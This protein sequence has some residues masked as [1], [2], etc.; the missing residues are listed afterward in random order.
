MWGHGLN[1]PTRE[2][3]ATPVGLL[4]DMVACQLI[5]E[6]APEKPVTLNENN[7]DEIMIPDLL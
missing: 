5:S 6:G 1:L 3:Y 2:I 7:L 4:Y